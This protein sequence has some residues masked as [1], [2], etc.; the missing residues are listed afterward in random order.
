[1]KK[2]AFAEGVRCASLGSRRTLCGNGDVSSLRSDAKMTDACLE[3]Q[4]KKKE[5][6]KEKEKGKQGSTEGEKR[7]NRGVT[8]EVKRR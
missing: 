1:M 2:T 6:N 7:V 5:K 3:L 4:K 8:K